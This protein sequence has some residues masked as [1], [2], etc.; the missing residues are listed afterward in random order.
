MTE[1]KKS[2]VRSQ[3][4]FAMVLSLFLIMVLFTGM[5]VMMAN[6]R[7]ELRMS[8]QAFETVQ[9]RFAAQAAV[10]K[11][12][13]L[14]ENGH[15]PSEF[16]PDRPLEVQVGDFAKVKAW[17]I[18]DANTGVYHLRS[19]REGVSFSKVI[20]QTKS[21]GSRV[22]VNDG[23]ALKAAGVDD[24]VWTELPPPPA[25]AYNTLGQEVDSVL[26]IG[27]D[28]FSANKNSQ[29][30]A[31]FHGTDTEALYLWDEG[32]QGWSAVPPAPGWETVG[33]VVQ[34]GG[35]P[36]LPNTVAL[37]DKKVF[38]FENLSRPAG[39]PVSV[40]SYYDLDSQSW[41]ST[42]GPFDGAR[43]EDGFVGPDDSFVAE[44]E[45]GGQRRAMQL[46]GG[47]WSELAPLP[48]GQTLEKVRANGPNGELYVT[49]TSGQLFELKDDVW[50][51]IQVPV[52]SDGPVGQLQS[53]DAGGALLFRN[54]DSDKTFRWDPSADPKAL[55]EI[56]EFRGMAGGGDEKE[57]TAQGFTTTAT[58]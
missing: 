28:Y 53:V 5:T 56:G 34:P 6:Y 45:H 43:L 38:G 54:P 37:G 29:L 39:A 41:G 20:A 3:R 48:N 18:E 30:A 16:P 12:H 9:Y 55:P 46:V 7:A 26:E 19:E 15:S 23:G 57:V 24:L 1:Y 58:Y 25:K 51:T 11:L 4:G 52:S 33:N 36:D 31:L 42:K 44:V 32:T 47:V 35:P 27:S 22:Y 49:S 10:N 8:Q 13:T 40:I 21:G 14:L 17:V 50:N 2:S